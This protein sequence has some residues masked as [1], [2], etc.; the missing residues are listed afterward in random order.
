[1][2]V[3]I[4]VVESAVEVMVVDLVAVA[5]LVTSAG[6]TVEVEE[7]VTGITVV[8]VDGQTVLVTGLAVL[9]IVLTT[10]CSTS[11]RHLTD[12]G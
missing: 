11:L 3:S 4:V 7:T 6:Y 5:V 9:T 8:E 10:I 1:M 2:V 12:S